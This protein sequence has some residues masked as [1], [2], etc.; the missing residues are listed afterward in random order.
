[1]WDKIISFLNA[2]IFHVLL[3]CILLYSVKWQIDK[4]HKILSIQSDEQIVQARAV[5]ENQWFEAINRLKNDEISYN[6]AL[7][8]QQ[9]QLNR[10]RKELEKTVTKENQSLDWL[11]HLKIKEQKRL[12]ELKQR[13]QAEIE[14]IEKLK[15]QKVKQ[16]RLKRETEERKRHETYRKKLEQAAQKRKQLEKQKRKKE[17]ARLAKEAETERQAE[18]ERQTRI[19]ARRAEQKRQAR[20]KEMEAKRKTE[21]KHEVDNKRLQY[22]DNLITAKITTLWR[23]TFYS[24]S[25]LSCEVKIYLKPGGEVS[26]VVIAQSSGNRDFDNAAQKI[27]YQASPLPVPDDY[28]F[29]EYRETEFKFKPYNS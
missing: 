29:D 13:Q 16:E 11:N 4:P 21:A 28:L 10:Q 24:Q 25:Y 20:L 27:I 3:V 15:L 22:F 7:Q 14:T 1:M 19:T 8:I 12:V 2:F 23:Q 5:D 18:A 26:S 17:K 9:R 6:K